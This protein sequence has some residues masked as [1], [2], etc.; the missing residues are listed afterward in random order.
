MS[1]WTELKKRGSEH[2]KKNPNVIEPIDLYRDGGI[3]RDFAVGSIIKYAYRNRKEI[4]QP[5]NPKDMDKI[6]HYA[7]ML[8]ALQ[9][10]ETEVERTREVLD[11]FK[12]KK[13]LFF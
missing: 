4:G 2:Y 6:S 13:K 5:I 1:R 7:E 8:L 12:A 11:C 3:L 10:E 9:E